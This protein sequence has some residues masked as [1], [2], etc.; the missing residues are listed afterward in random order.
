M[1][2][3]RKKKIIIIGPAYPYRGGPSTFVSYIYKNICD[4]FEVKIF[5]YKLLYPSFLFPGTTQ[6]DKSQSKKFIVPSKRII[7][8]INPF[9]WISAAVKINNA[10]ADLVIFDWWHPFFGPCHFS[11]SKL[12][13]KKY[14]NKILFI[15][16]NF[17]SH[18]QNKVDKILTRLGLKNAGCFLAL[19]KTVG[20]Q[21][22]INFPHKI[23]YRS[24]LPSFDLY[25][26]SENFDRKTERTELNYSD[27]DKVLLFF[28]YVRKYK[29]LDVLL[30]AFPQIL[31]RIPEVKLL[32][33]GEFYENVSSYT[34]IINRLGIEE[35]V[36]L[37]NEFVPN[38]KVGKYFTASDLSV[39]PYR[40]AT[41]SAVL[42]VSYSFNKPVLVTNVGG[43][44]EFVK[45]N[46]TGLIVEP[47]NP[48]ALAEGVVK[49]FE[50]KNQIDFENNIEKFKN[51]KGFNNLAE[52]FNLIIEGN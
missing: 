8:S 10:N 21:L 52:I 42:N 34:Q 4:E 46:E 5:N 14:G 2:N 48:D 27:E 41:Q 20:D 1:E 15:T 18:E 35:K 22:R 40:S 33:V 25:S 13:K 30:E 24:E 38:E 44:G 3:S 23:I 12:I 47:E 16:E 28:G 49:F 6:Y 19:S 11:I 45:N 9:N 31:R 37:I 43:L 50:L 29:G 7:N 36:K 26:Q 51:R 32:I 17:I 39:L